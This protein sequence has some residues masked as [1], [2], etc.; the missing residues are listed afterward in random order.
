MQVRNFSEADAQNLVKFV[1]ECFGWWGL[2]SAKAEA[3]FRWKYFRNPF[4]NS[5]LGLVCDEAEQILGFE[6]L[7]RWKLLF[8]ENEIS[9]VIGTDMLTHPNYRGRGV[10]SALV[11][12]LNGEAQRAGIQLR[13]SPLHFPIESHMLQK[14][15][16]RQVRNCVVN[17]VQVHNYVPVLMS[18]LKSR[19][20]K[21][22][23]RRLVD[24]DFIKEAMSVQTLLSHDGFANLLKRDRQRCSRDRL[25]TPRSMEYVKWRYCENPAATYYAAA[26]E[27]GYSLAA[28]AVFRPICYRGIK[29]IQLREL[30]VDR[31]DAV[32][33]LLEELVRATDADCIHGVWSTGSEKD[34]ILRR[35]GFVP[36]FGR[37]HLLV[38]ILNPGMMGTPFRPG[39]WDFNTSDVVWN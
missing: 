7:V 30:F 2:E 11:S 13:L 18:L 27:Q 29:I 9:C 16:L 35:L 25:T 28:A 20:P 22:T 5:F 34:Q 37:T 12:Y 24:D 31:D 15:G 38:K 10:M 26:V 23:S 17:H 21:S 36:T 33:T 4:G 6:G 3:Y 19:L 8:D 39:G 32:S 14:I 1:T